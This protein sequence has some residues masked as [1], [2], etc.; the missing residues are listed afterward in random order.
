MVAAFNVLD[1]RFRQLVR[2]YVVE[3]RHLD[4]VEC[5]AQ[6]FGHV[7]GRRADAAI[8]AE[9]ILEVRRRA[10][11]RRPLVNRLRVRASDKPK[12]IGTGDDRALTQV[13]Q[14]HFMVP[15][16][17]DIRFKANHAAVAAAR[18]GLKGHERIL[19]GSHRDGTPRR[20]RA[21]YSCRSPKDTRRRNLSPAQLNPGDLIQDARRTAPTA[22]T[23]PPLARRHR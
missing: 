7:A 23:R 17:I 3:Q 9:V 8:F 16:E 14:L 4:G 22:A 11:R 13:E 6:C 10:S 2:N 21:F 20:L 18:M 1:R 19:S 5:A 15:Y 12:S